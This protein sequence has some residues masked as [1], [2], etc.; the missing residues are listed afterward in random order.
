M[1]ILL[2]TEALHF[3]SI[4]MVFISKI[5]KS[6][7][8]SGRIYSCWKPARPRARE[9]N[10]GLHHDHEN[11]HHHHHHFPARGRAPGA[12]ARPRAPS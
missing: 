12:R 7:C 6:P 11:D 2:F 10:L 5:L 8:E 3:N 1:Q 9:P 4:Q